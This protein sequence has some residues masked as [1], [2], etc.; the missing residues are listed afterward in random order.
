MRDAAVAAER[1]AEPA[2]GDAAAVA[3]RQH[4]AGARRYA[5][6]AKHM[7]ILQMLEPVSLVCCTGECPVAQPSRQLARLMMSSADT[8][9]G[10]TLLDTLLDG[11]SS[12]CAANCPALCRLIPLLLCR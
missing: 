4:A 6:A 9:L 2:R 10:F 5:H 8:N 3:R 11:A 7:H 1:R 12:S